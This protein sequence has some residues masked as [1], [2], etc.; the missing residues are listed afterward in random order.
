[1]KKLNKQHKSIPK[2]TYL[3]VTVLVLGI[4]ALLIRNMIIVRPQVAE[5]VSTSSCESNIVKFGVLNECSPGKFKSY[6]VTCKNGTAIE[7]LS[8][9]T[10]FDYF[11]AYQE[12]QATCGR[13]CTMVAPSPTPQASSSATPTPKPTTYPFPSVKP[14]PTP[15]PTSDPSPLVSCETE[16]YKLP[17][18]FNTSALTSALL[19]KYKVIGRNITAKSGDLFAFNMRLTNIKNYPLTDGYLALSAWTYSSKG[20]LAPFNIT[21]KAQSCLEYPDKS[22]RCGVSQLILGQNQSVRPDTFM[23][24]SINQPKI[25]TKFDLTYQGTYSRSAFSCSTAVLNVLGAPVRK[26]Y[27]Y[28]R[29][30]WCRYVVPN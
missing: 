9:G 18:K 14:S 11:S 20:E 22:L 5:V 3:G 13:T 17:P 23:V 7:K 26:C 6:S 12:A 1:M 24:V 4:V 28:G 15:P 29:F 30:Q 25:T 10:C 8:S 16:V 2:I 27:G 21:Q 19:A